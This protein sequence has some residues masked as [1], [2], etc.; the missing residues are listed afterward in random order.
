[1][2]Y[3]EDKMENIVG[4]YK[5]HGFDVYIS[6]ELRAPKRKAEDQLN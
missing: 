1:M 6:E 4:F 3:T 2:L 5:N